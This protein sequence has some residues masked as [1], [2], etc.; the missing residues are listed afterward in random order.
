MEWVLESGFVGWFLNAGFE[1]S[2]MASRA[3]L[4]CRLTE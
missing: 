2:I 4:P 1:V 3:L